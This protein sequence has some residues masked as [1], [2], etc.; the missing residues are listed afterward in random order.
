MLPRFSKDI[1][2]SQLFS[3]YSGFQV[4]ED[5]EAVAGNSRKNIINREELGYIIGNKTY[6][7]PSRRV[8]RCNGWQVSNFPGVHGAGV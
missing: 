3:L 1:S 5:T 6:T 8:K 2:Q 4:D 7:V